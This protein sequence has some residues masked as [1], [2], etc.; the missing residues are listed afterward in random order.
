[1][2]SRI[3]LKLIDQAIVPAVLLLTARVLSVICISRQLSIPYEITGSGFTFGSLQD[4][5]KVNSYSA[6]VIIA[7][8]AI[9]LGYVLLKASI[10]H[11]T[12]IKPG[13]AAKMFSLNLQ[14]LIQSSLDIYSQGAIWLSYSYLVTA[15]VGL[16]SLF[17]MIVPWVFY[18]ALASSIV[19]TVVLILDVE[20]ELA[21]SKADSSFNESELEEDGE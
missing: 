13:T 15:A 16:M 9:G 4:Y 2:F 14:P 8:L 5:V 12:H 10:F 17:D 18:V 3:L 1:M 19:S 6:L 7:V 11:D 21:E 20:N